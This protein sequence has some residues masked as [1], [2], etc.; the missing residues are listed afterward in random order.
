MQNLIIHTR[1]LRGK[2][3]METRTVEELSVKYDNYNLLS[4]DGII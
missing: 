4:N 3:L 1:Y 2:V